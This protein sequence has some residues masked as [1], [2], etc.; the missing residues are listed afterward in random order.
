[1]KQNLG[2]TDRLIRISAAVVIAVLVYA[3][4]VTGPWAMVLLAV[5]AVLVITGFIRF[6]P[7]YRLFGIYTCKKP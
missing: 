6:C 4:V 5:A 3:E 1:M 2:N 7:L